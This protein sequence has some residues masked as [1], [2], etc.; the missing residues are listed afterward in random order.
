M[1]Q[2]WRD[3]LDDVAQAL[4]ARTDRARRSLED[5]IRIPSVS[6]HGHDQSVLRGSAEATA[7]LLER[8]GLEHVELVDLDDAPPYVYGAWLRA[9]ESAPSVL[10]Y[11]HHD[12]QPVNTPDRWR[13]E[14]FVPTERGGR[15]YGRGS[16]DDKAGIVVHAAAIEAWLAA[17]GRLPVNV[18]VLIEGEEEVGSPHLSQFLAAHEGRLQADA[19]VVTDVANWKVGVP[20]LTYSLRGL[21]EV[22]VTATA[23]EQPLHSGMWGGPVPD[24]LTGLLKVLATLTDTRGRPAVP[25]LF[26]DVRPPS[27]GERAR[28]E[29]LEADPNLLRAEAG[30]LEGVEWVG[31][32]DLP[33]LERMWLQPTLNVIGLDVPSLR[34]ASNQLIARARAKVSIRLA[35]GQDPER[36]V[37]VV[38]EYIRAH[39]PWGLHVTTEPGVSTPAWVTDPTGPAFQGAEEALRTA[40]GADPA[41]LGCGGS[42]PMVGPL[43]EALGGVPCLLTGIEDPATNAH[44]EDESL[45]LG[46]FVRACLAEAF[47]FQELADRVPV[48]RAQTGSRSGG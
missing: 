33:L 3:E 39:A 36:V 31:D 40:F 13:S 28:L 16:A 12:V 2:T 25:G 5:L 38:S 30:M 6:A 27:A 22:Y 41:Y 15:L 46:D 11:A 20:G 32:P 26:D 48:A 35:P 43:S 45:H 7:R 37:R 29:A 8:C 17:R 4:L 42:I 9:G 24:A 34:D 1:D 47:L 19:I 21:A 23:L 14:P 10:L 18:K 44:G